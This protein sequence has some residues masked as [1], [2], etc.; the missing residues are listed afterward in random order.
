[1]EKTVGDKTLALFK[2]DITKQH[3]DAIGNAANAALAG[4]GGVDGAIHRAAGPSLMDDLRHYRGCPTGSAVITHA[5]D[6][7]AK[8]VIHAVGPRWRG[9]DHGEAELLAGAYRRTLELADG[10]NCKTLALPSI[11][12][13]VYGYPVAQAAT[14]ALKTVHDYLAKDAQVVEKVTF[15]LFDDATFEAYHDVLEAY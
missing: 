5:G 14:V 10:A 15:V 8:H 9:G 12:T 3:V 6:L 13:G 2:G 7:H 11:S 1:M 4:G